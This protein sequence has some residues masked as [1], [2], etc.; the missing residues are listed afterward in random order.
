VLTARVSQHDGIGLG[1]DL[2]SA[3]QDVAGRRVEHLHDRSW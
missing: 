1:R 3:E 2:L